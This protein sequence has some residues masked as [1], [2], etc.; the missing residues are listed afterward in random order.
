MIVRALS[1]CGLYLFFSWISRSV[2]YIREVDFV[3][4]LANTLWKFL[5]S[6]FILIFTRLKFLMFMWLYL[7]FFSSVA[8]GF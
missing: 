1:V 5:F 7:S 2:L 6:V 8:S 4:K 3:I